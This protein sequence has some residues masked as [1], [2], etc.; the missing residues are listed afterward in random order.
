ML[1]I[2]YLEPAHWP[3]V[4]A[5]GPVDLGSIQFIPKTLKMLLDTSLLNTQQYKVYI[6]G[7]SGCN[8][9]KGVVPSPTPCYSSYLKGSLLVT[10]FTYLHIIYS[11]LTVILVLVSDHWQYL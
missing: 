8:P 2:L 6:K 9:G 1:Y 3:R 10:N 5:N 7:E 4:F 11:S